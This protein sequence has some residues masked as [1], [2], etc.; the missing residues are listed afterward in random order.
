MRC[1]TCA[2]ASKACMKSLRKYE[3]RENEK[4]MDVEGRK[5]RVVRGAGFSCIE[6]CGDEALELVDA[7]AVWI[8]SN[9]LLA[10]PGS[11]SSEQ[12]PLGGGAWTAGC[13]HALAGAN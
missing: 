5:V 13:A 9:P 10:G 6:F 1:Y 8:A 4:K 2:S 11:L 3:E 7:G 12:N